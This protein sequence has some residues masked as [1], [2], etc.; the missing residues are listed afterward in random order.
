MK[1]FFLA[2][3]GFVLKVSLC[4]APSLP[5]E[6]LCL[7]NSKKLYGKGMGIGAMQTSLTPPNVRL[8]AIFVRLVS[9]KNVL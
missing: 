9:L 4:L 3:V 1:G 7:E 6:T 5:R 2:S 8:S